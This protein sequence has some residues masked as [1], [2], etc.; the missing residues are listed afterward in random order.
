MHRFAK[1]CLLEEEG[2]KQSMREKLERR[3]LY[4]ERPAAAEDC[5]SPPK[6]IRDTAGAVPPAAATEVSPEAAD[7]ADGKL[8]EQ[9]VVKQDTQELIL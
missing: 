4:H 3:A 2:R 5:P 7:I 1:K 6:K 8:Q 9:S